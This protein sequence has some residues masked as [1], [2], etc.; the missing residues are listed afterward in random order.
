MGFQA[1][2]CFLGP[3]TLAFLCG[4][5]LSEVLP[6]SAQ[7]CLLCLG[8]SCAFLYALKVLGDFAKS[9]WRFIATVCAAINYQAASQLCQGHALEQP[10]H[11][12]QQN[13]QYR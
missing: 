8:A 2:F 13:W 1:W 5:F 12:G 11:E 3:S 7:L 4:G 6:T 10:K 9:F